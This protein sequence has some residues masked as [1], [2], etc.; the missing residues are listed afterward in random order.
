MNDNITPAT[1]TAEALRV[2]RIM[3]DSHM[4]R[5]LDS[6]HATPLS[7]QQRHRIFI[8]HGTTWWIRSNDGYCEII[9]PDEIRKLDTWRRRLTEGP[10]WV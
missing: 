5:L 6:G 2:P 1:T 9:G 7:T 4:Q 8:R 3:P 10:L